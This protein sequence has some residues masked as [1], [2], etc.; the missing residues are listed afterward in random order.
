MRTFSLAVSFNRWLFGGVLCLSGTL[1]AVSAVTAGVPAPDKFMPYVELAP[2]KVNGRQLSISI[3]ARSRSDRSY[4]AG[5]AEEVVKVVCE[6]VTP[7]TGK[8]LVIIGS[9][10]EPHPVVQLRQFLAL[11]KAGKLDPGV[12]A[13]APELQAMLDQWEETVNDEN[14]HGREAKAA[15]EAKDVDDLEFERILT[16]LPL[17]LKGI[18][19][20]IY[21]IAWREGFDEARVEA[22]LR[23]LHPADLDGSLFA[24]FDWV[25][26]LPPKR[27]FDQVLDEI[28]ADALKE[29]GA[30][31]MER[32]AARS[33]MLVV[34]PRIRRAIE[35]VRQG[36]LFMTVI[37]ARTHF[38]PAAVSLL[39]GAYLDVLMPDDE[40]QQVAGN[41]D[42]ERAVNSVRA[43]MQALE[44]TNTP[45]PETSAAN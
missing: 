4:A 5:F 42:H 44:I 10:G 8:G 23:A 22:A 15:K 43:A 18:G 40:K 20:K 29:D 36:L 11:A 33:V 37:Q 13:R 17:P 34:K 27:A 24:H 6:S 39:T 2:F 19:A 45:S 16:A 1:L 30:G 28:V 41:N 26:Y 7:N 32:M 12:A 14:G 21:Q 25:F 35:A 9:K 38:D 3:H 31:F